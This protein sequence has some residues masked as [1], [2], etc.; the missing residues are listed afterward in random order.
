MPDIPPLAVWHI[1]MLGRLRATERISTKSIDRFRT[2]KTGLLLAYLCLHPNRDHGREELV[3]RFWGDHGVEEGRQSGRQALSSL[4]TVFGVGE[5]APLVI[6]RDTA[7]WEDTNAT[8]DVAA[9]R[10]AARTAFLSKTIDTWQVAITRYTGSLLLGAF[11]DWVLTLREA[12]EETYLQ[13]L[14]GLC[15]SYLAQKR[16]EDAGGRDSGRAGSGATS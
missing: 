1:E 9:F 16:W 15:T 5:A 7:R 11:D 4:R 12:L 8:T 10:A 6:A 14:D 3:E 2:R 13:C